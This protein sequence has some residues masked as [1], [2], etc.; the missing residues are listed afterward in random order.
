[1]PSLDLH[2]KESRIHENNPRTKI[3]MSNVSLRETPFL[4]LITCKNEAYK[5]YRKRF[6]STWRP[7]TLH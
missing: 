1:M 7:E 4:L 2:A 3:V 6:T 5:F